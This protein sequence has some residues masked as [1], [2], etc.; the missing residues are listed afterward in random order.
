MPKAIVYGVTHR[1]LLNQDTRTLVTL[2]F[3]GNDLGDR[4]L[5]D[6]VR[7]IKFGLD[8]DFSNFQMQLVEGADGEDTSVVHGFQSMPDS[9]RCGF[10]GQPD[11]AP[12]HDEK[13]APMFCLHDRMVLDRDRA[14]GEP[15]KCAICDAVCSCDT[16]GVEGCVIH[17]N[18]AAEKAAGEETEFAA[19]GRRR[20]V[21]DA[22]QPVGAA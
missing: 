12:I 22:P 6:L 13:P 9:D 1:R 15:P 14:A 17:A 3:N 7:Q 18:R 4:L 16:S 8:V 20:R 10:C 21:A 19:N 5:G 11:G 2:S